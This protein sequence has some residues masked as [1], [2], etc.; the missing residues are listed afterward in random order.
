M[1]ASLLLSMS[2]SSLLPAEPWGDREQILHREVDLPNSLLRPVGF[3]RQ[4]LR[5]WLLM[6]WRRRFLR[7]IEGLKYIE[8]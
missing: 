6:S 8:Q 1:A 4:Q 5:K 7:W 3:S 2:F